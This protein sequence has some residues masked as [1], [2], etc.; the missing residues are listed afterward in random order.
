M[1]S[2]G[3]VQILLLVL[4]TFASTA[5]ARSW[6]DVVDPSMYRNVDLDVHKLHV[7]AERDPFLSSFPR[8]KPTS[9]APRGDVDVEVTPTAS[10]TAVW[11][12]VGQNG[13]CP[14]GQLLY[15]I[16]MVDTWGDGWG[17]TTLTITRMVNPENQL[18]VV[19]KVATET[20]T[21]V[22]EIIPV[23]EPVG[24]DPS[25]PRQIFKG[26]LMAGSEGYEYICMEPDQ[27]YQVV[28]EGGLWQ[29]EVAWGIRQVALGVPRE[30]S[31]SYL[32]VAKGGSPETCQISVAVNGERVCSVTCGLSTKAPSVAPTT[33]T[34][35][36]TPTLVPT[37]MKNI[38]P[39][40]PPPSPSMFPSDM[41]SL[42]PTS[43]PTMINNVITDEESESSSGAPSDMPSLVPTSVPTEEEPTREGLGSLGG[44][45]FGGFR[46]A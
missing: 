11:E 40:D 15:E 44:F 19:K 25:F 2:Q 31:P 8:P 18:G 43:F 20:G 3:S 16:R 30:Q 26:S 33:L 9:E 37:V 34:P 24:D 45:G 5:Y 35:T 14:E 42:V 27:C 4:A 38:A 1:M 36:Q 46:R 32:T 22:T 41:P 39:D 6:R 21:V 10:P 28:A 29:Q 12:M 23:R 13:G 17:D 7:T